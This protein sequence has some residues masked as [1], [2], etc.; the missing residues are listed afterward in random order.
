MAAR[1]SL[2]LSSAYN[3]P[4][5]IIFPLI[6]KSTTMAAAPTATDAGANKETP[7]HAAFPSPKNKAP[8][9][10]RAEVLEWLK[11][12]KN[13]SGAL[14]FV[15]VDLR[16]AD[17]EVSLQGSPPGEHPIRRYVQSFKFLAAIVFFLPA[18]SVYIY[19]Y[20]RLN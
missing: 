3:T 12:S 4:S 14:D 15:L 7:W 13:S 6:R 1:I 16:R 20:L 8:T 18:L 17:H 5:R 9:V 2:A 19:I 10:P 11:Q